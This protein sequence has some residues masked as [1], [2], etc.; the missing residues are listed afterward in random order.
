MKGISS[1]AKF[2]NLVAI[3]TKPFIGGT[4]TTSFPLKDG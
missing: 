4:I 2:T 1:A 3:F